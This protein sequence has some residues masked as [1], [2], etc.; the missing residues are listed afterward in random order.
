MTKP[1]R[2]QRNSGSTGSIASGVTP[3]RLADLRRWNLR[4]TVLHAA[5]AA[6]ILVIASDFAI[7]VTSTYPQGP[8]GTSLATPE[9]LFDVRIGPAI[10][11]FL[12][13]A[14]FDHFTLFTL[15]LSAAVPATLSGEPVAVQVGVFVGTVMV[16]VGGV[17]S[18]AADAGSA[19]APSTS[20]RPSIKPAALLMIL[21][22]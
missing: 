21:P 3:E 5:Q 8:P 6:L 22:V 13:L 7:T 20:A 12:L 19:I 10:A 14:A 4:L 17:V 16:T 9:A 18:L 15:T 2:P 1:A 11:V